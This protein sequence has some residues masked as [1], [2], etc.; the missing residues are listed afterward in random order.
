VKKA[1]I[2]VLVIAIVGIAGEL[3]Y[4]TISQ[5]G[6][7]DALKAYIAAVQ[8][9]EFSII[10]WLNYRTQKQM[11]ILARA[12]DPDVETLVDKIYESGERAFNAAQRTDDLTITWA[13][14]FFF[15][16]EMDYSVIGAKKTTTAGTPSAGYR[17]RST[18]TVFVAVTYPS[19]DA[20][21]VYRDERIREANLEVHMI[22]SR[23]AV[24]GMDTKPVKDGW[25]YH[26]SRVDD[27]SIVYQDR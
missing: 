8:E 16:P 26:W 5:K 9:R 23:D 19:P 17:S 25:L 24:K 6:P 1:I 13:E 12:N 4:N 2:F 15:V 7:E 27:D 22:Q 21:P 18:A 10:F 3:A 20:A 14:K 11:N